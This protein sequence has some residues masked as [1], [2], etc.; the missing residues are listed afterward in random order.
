MAKK[1]ASTKKS[2]KSSQKKVDSKKPVL[3]KTP[4]AKLLAKSKVDS[5]LLKIGRKAPAFKLQNEAG[6]WI[7]LSDLKGSKVVIYFYPKDLTPGCTQESSDFRDEHSRLMKAGVSVF[8][9]SKD[10]ILSHQKFKTKLNL[11]F[12]LLADVEGKMCES[13]GVW[14]EKSLYGRKYM[15]IERTTFLIDESGKIQKIYPKVSVKGHVA[16]VLADIT[17]NK[18][19]GN[20]SNE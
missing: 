7:K 4:T 10:P 9:V 8:G 15:G 6:E 11:P 20:E 17:E 2:Q 13:Y 12:S 1:A 16:E 18:S 19:W 14:K 3:T 5:S